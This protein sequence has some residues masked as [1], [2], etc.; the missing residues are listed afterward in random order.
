[1]SHESKFEV[2]TKVT[3]VSMSFD[4]VEELSF[5]STREG[6]GNWKIA[7]VDVWREL[8][9]INRLY[10]SCRLG[11]KDVLVANRLDWFQKGFQF[12]S[13]DMEYVARMLKENEVVFGHTYNYGGNFE[14]AARYA[15][16]A[17]LGH[18]LKIQTLTPNI[19]K[20]IR[21]T[22]KF[23]TSKFYLVGDSLV[24]LADFWAQRMG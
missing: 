4:G 13:M 11:G 8:G 14:N 17:V 3:K 20:A 23:E 7:G 5:A 18:L 22:A 12:G 9:K 2:V 6:F 16:L 10:I 19:L 21:E 24:P 15:I 1:M